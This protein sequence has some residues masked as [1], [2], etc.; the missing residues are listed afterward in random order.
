M[1]SCFWSLV[2]KMLTSHGTYQARFL[3][4]NYE[5]GE[6]EQKNCYCKLPSDRAPARLAFY[7]QKANKIENGPRPD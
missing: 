7:W 5:F 3:N 6:N 1:E 2:T 4:N